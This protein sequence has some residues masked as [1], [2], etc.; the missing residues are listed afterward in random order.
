MAPKMHLL[1][2]QRATRSEE[3]RR[4][5]GA[6]EATTPASSPPLRSPPPK[7][8]VNAKNILSD[9][10]ID[11]NFLDSERFWIANLI[12]DMG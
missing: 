12:I 4:G 3:S 6:R 7:T 5:R 10:I 8:L 9:R 1:Q 11:M 2:H